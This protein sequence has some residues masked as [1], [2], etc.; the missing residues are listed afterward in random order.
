MCNF[1][2]LSN[3][4]N[5]FNALL[6]DCTIEFEHEFFVETEAVTHG[7]VMKNSQGIGEP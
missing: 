5:S 3:Y 2:L 7:F 1:L 4:Y 6:Q